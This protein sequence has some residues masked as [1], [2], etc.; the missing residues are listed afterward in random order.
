[1]WGNSI[2]YGGSFPA[3]RDREPHSTISIVSGPAMLILYPKK[4]ISLIWR[5]RLIRVQEVVYTQ[6]CDERLLHVKLGQ[7]FRTQEVEYQ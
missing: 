5:S 2:L 6:V 4:G 7:S 1:M 3:G